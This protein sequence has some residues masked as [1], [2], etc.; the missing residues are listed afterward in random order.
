LEE[1]VLEFGPST[2]GSISRAI[3][4]TPKSK[5]FRIAGLGSIGIA[6]LFGAGM[7][8]VSQVSEP[9]ERLP[10]IAV[11]SSGD[12]VPGNALKVKGSV[13]GKNNPDNPWVLKL[14]K[15]DRVSST[16]K[17]IGSTSKNTLDAQVEL[18]KK[19]SLTIRFTLSESRTENAR[20]STLTIKPLNL[21]NE[22]ER[23]YKAF[24]ASIR[25]EKLFQET[26]EKGEQGQRFRKF[27]ESI[28]DP[29]YYDFSSDRWK[30]DTKLAS[31]N[32]GQEPLDYITDTTINP[33]SITAI[34]DPVQFSNCLN[35]ELQPKPGLWYTV[36]KT[37]HYIGEWLEYDYGF[38][39]DTFKVS[40][41]R[42]YLNAGACFG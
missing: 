22:L 31:Y 19:G 18:P 39:T 21:E 13:T 1:R 25:A 26:G 11:D 12:L 36:D 2:R 6:V 24:D 20:Y 30:S 10:Q 16:W 3:K 40:G 33:R 35:K 27:L 37:V 38:Y 5:T 42:I 4:D 41:N 17:N 14:D 8:L 28:V 9:R 15:Y 29:A 34:D 32:T 23:I 7:L